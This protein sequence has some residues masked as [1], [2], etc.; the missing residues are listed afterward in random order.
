MNDISAEAVPQLLTKVRG[1]VR[2]TPE[3]IQKQRLELLAAQL[4]RGVPAAMVARQ[5]EV[6]GS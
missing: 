3:G 2:R 5:L 4:E 6:M 1:M